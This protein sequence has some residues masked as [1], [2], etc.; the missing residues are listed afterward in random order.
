MRITSRN[1]DYLELAKQALS[2]G[3]SLEEVLMGIGSEAKMA[4][5]ECTDPEGACRL[6]GEFYGPDGHHSPRCLE[7]GEMA[8]AAERVF[9]RLD[10]LVVSGNLVGLAENGQPKLTRMMIRHLAGCPECGA[11]V[12]EFCR[13]V[14]IHPGQNG[15]FDNLD[16]Y[17]SH[18]GRM[19][20]AQK[21]WHEVHTPQPV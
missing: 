4:A 14:K 15:P 3:A 7:L 20:A 5:A 12:D 16:R 17:R 11:K 9:E 18:S 2:L 1:N 8:Q 13:N 6:S 21:N 10:R 19:R